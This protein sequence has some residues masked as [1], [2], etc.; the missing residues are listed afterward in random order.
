MSNVAVTVASW[1]G[2]IELA[3]I[4]PSLLRGR[5]AGIEKITD[6][7]MYEARKYF[8]IDGPGKQSVCRRTS[9]RPEETVPDIVARSRYAAVHRAKAES[10][11]L[12]DSCVHFLPEWVKVTVCDAFINTIPFVSGDRRLMTGR[13][14]QFTIPL[15]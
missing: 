8:S 6:R 15:D 10:S 2:E 3:V 12:E 7:R 9:S 11:L 1:V 4:H 13:P 14:R 5:K